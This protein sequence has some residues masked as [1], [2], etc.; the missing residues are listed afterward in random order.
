MPWTAKRAKNIFVIGG[1]MGAVRC[2]VARAQNRRGSR[3]DVAQSGHHPIHS[4][5]TMINASTIAPKTSLTRVA[6]GGL[7]AHLDMRISQIGFI[8]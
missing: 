6:E 3:S 5:P 4:I 2:P 8:M 7:R 1:N